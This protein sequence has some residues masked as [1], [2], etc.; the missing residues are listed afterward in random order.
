MLYLP[1][2]TALP[3]RVHGAFVSDE[4]VRRVVEH[5][6]QRGGGPDYIEGVLEEVPPLRDG[7]VGGPTGTQQPSTSGHHSRPRS[8]GA[9]CT[10][11]RPPP[12]HP[13]APPRGHETCHH[14]RAPR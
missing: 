1:P 13:P 5:L 11:P 3:E 4:E 14:R 12:H 6:T 8:A 2:G 9:Q 10:A 7:A